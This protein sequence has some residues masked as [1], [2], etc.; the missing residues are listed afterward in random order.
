MTI[1]VAGWAS[2][3]LALEASLSRV[4]SEASDRLT[5]IANTFDATV[6]RFRYLPTVLSLE[7]PIRDLYRSPRD[8]RSIAAA[9]RYLKSLNRAAG[10][11]ELFVLDEAGVALAAS[12]FDQDTSFVGHNY[13]FRSYFQDALRAGEG[14]IYAVG[15]TTGLPGYFLS[16]RVVEGDRTLGVTV[17][18]IDLSA[19]EADWARAGD[20]VAVEDGNGVIF[21][22]SRE[23]WKYHPLEPL[24]VATIA[25][26]NETRQFGSAI[27]SSPV[28]AVE[29][30]TGN[31]R[32]GRAG[33]PGWPDVRE[34]A[35]HTRQLTAHGWQLLVFSD[36]DD[37]RRYAS[38]VSSAA[39]LAAVAGLLIVLVAY[40]RRQV[41]R[42]KLEAHDE[43]ERRVTE[44][45][46]ELSAVNAKL[47][48]EVEERIRAE[49]GLR[50]TQESLI[51]SAKLASLGQALAGVAH[52]IN[53]PLAALNTYV[54][55]SRILLRRNELER[56]AANLDLMSS[57]AE[58]M[59]ALIEH[60]RMFARKETGAR[61]PVDLPVV[62]GNA[63][64]LVEYRIRNEG[65]KVDMSMPSAPV[66]VMAN[67]VR[68]EQ[69]LVN[70]LSNAI[71]AMH[72]TEQR[73]LGI[74]L[75]WDGERA[76]IEVSDT[77]HGIAPEHVKSLFDPFFTTKDIG[78]GLGLG[79]SISYGIIRECGGDIMVESAPRAGARF[80]VV[81][82]TMSPA[83]ARQPS[84]LHA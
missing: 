13:A 58:R 83:D 35:V 24:P 72:D 2:Y 42:A 59:M 5:L 34:Y 84:G 74:V 77:G 53:Q 48:T 27:E 62:I 28:L 30:R 23:R 50:Q 9:N 32:I 3:R 68:L 17:V 19:L 21:L 45:T 41:M 69:V 76:V 26:L 71:D 29:R 56:A 20:V 15:A 8:A 39:T 7:E 4:D 44:R 31:A 12:N 57:I 55:S 49:Q 75:D 63:M 67:P 64:R 11:A 82:P 1:A 70:L 18:K 65:I 80:R 47:S 38:T 6:A 66:Y 25:Q 40:Q 33:E 60:L 43:L 36:V 73:L 78:Q 22:S 52:E 79:L 46:A 61:S 37:V 10:S 51:Q 54:A 14:H 81:L 16:H